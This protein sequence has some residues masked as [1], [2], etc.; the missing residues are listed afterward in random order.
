MLERPG[1]AALGGCSRRRATCQGYRDGEPGDRCASLLPSPCG[2]F[3]GGRQLIG[4][5]RHGEHSSRRGRRGQTLR[6]RDLPRFRSASARH[7]CTH[8]VRWYGRGVGQG[9]QLEKFCAQAGIILQPGVRQQGID[10]L[11]VVAAT[12]CGVFAHDV[13][14]LSSARFFSAPNALRCSCFT[15]P[16]DLPMMS[17]VSSTDRSATTLS[18]R[19][20]R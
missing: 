4:G 13:P 6:R 18:A 20:S 19:T 3:I 9:T 2:K 8:G 15:A 17:A 12:R 10:D 11:L 1:N 16:W 7:Q 14:F 5:S